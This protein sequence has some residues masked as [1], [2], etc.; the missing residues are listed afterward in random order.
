[1]CVCGRKPEGELI[2]RKPIEADEEE[3]KGNNRARSA[4]LRIIERRAEI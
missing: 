3:L 1:V 4:K 2:N